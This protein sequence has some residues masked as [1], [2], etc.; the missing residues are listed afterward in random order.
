MSFE[1]IEIGRV[2]VFGMVVVFG[3]LIRK[4]RYV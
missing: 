4:F 3:V 2:L 1:V